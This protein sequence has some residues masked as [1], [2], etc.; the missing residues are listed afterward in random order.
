MLARLVQFVCDKCR[1]H[2]QNCVQLRNDNMTSE[3]VETLA[4]LHVC[5]DASGYIN[6]IGM[7]LDLQDEN[8]VSIPLHDIDCGEVNGLPGLI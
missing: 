6:E 3:L 5:T 2:G 7:W 4:D 8:R 1:P